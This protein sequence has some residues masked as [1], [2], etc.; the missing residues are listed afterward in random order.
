MESLDRGSQNLRRVYP[1]IRSAPRPSNG[2]TVLASRPMAGS[3]GSEPWSFDERRSGFEGSRMRRL[4]CHAV[5]SRQHLPDA[6][7]LCT[8]ALYRTDCVASRCCKR[9]TKAQL[10]LL[11][12]LGFDYNFRTTDV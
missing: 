5:E 8:D 4:L 1:G 2:E 11:H 9:K 12:E 3:A 10:Q 6:C 7:Q